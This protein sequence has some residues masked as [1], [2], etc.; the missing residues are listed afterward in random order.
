MASDE[1]RAL[2]QSTDFESKT[3]LRVGGGETPLKD[4]ASLLGTLDIDIG[5][6]WAK[7]GV[8]SHWPTGVV[9]Y[10]NL[11]P[12]HLQPTLYIFHPAFSYQQ[13]TATKLQYD[14]SSSSN[15]A[16]EYDAAV[17]HFGVD[18][19]L[20]GRLGKYLTAVPMPISATVTTVTEALSVDGKGSPFAVGIDGQGVG[21]PL[22]SVVFINA[23]S[24]EDSSPA[25][26]GMAVC[27]RAPGAKDRLLGVR[28]GTKL[29]YWRSLMGQGEKWSILKGTHHGRAAE[30]P[31]S[32]GQY[33]RQG[34]FI[35]LQSGT[36]TQSPSSA[37]SIMTNEHLMSLYEGVQ[38]AEIRL[39]HK[40]R[41]G[42]GAEL[43]QVDLFGA[44]PLP[45]WADRP[46]LSGKYLVLPPSTRNGGPEALSRAFPGAHTPLSPA[47]ALSTLPSARQ[48]Q[49]LVREVLLSL[50]GVEGEYIR[51]VSGAPDQA[52]RPTLPKLREIK[53]AMDMSTIDRA[54]ATQVATILPICEH[55]I[56]I[57]EFTRLHSRL[58]HGLVSHALAAAIKIVMREF[59]LLVAQLE[60]QAQLSN[61]SLQRIVFLLQPAKATLRLLCL[62]VRR[63]WDKAGGGLLDVLHSFSLE[64]GDAKAK[65]LCVHLLEKSSRPFLHMLSR[66]IFRGELEDAYKEF[67]IHEDTSISQE[68]LAEDFNAQYWE[69]RY[70]LKVAH[71]PKVFKNIASRALTAGKYLNVVKGCLETGLDVGLTSLQLPIE[72]DLVLD[73]EGSAIA[74]AEVV[75]EAYVYSSRAL[76]RLLEE[77]HG[78]LTHLKSLSRFFLLE[79]GDF[80]IQFMDTAEEELR[81]EA[82]DIALPRI[83]GLLQLAVQTSTLA[84]DPHKEDLSCTL[85]THNLIQHLHLIQSAGMVN[86]DSG[87]REREAYSSMSSQGFK[88]VEALTLDYRVNWPVSLLLSRRSITKYQLL[89]RLLYFSKHVELRVLGS[90]Q[91]HQYTK[92]L[93]VRASMGQAYCLRHRMLHFLQNFVYY[94]A[95]EVICP[96]VHEMNEG[97][98]DAQD[99]DE[100]LGLHERFLDTC[101]KECLLA[102][103]DLL[104]N[105]TKIMTT[106]LLFADQMR[107]FSDSS[108]FD[109]DTRTPR[110]RGGERKGST[111]SNKDAGVSAKRRERLGAQSEYV[112]NE[113]AHESFQRMLAKFADTFDAQVFSP[114]HS[115]NSS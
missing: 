49:L 11:L 17:I 67:M 103:Q 83:Q 35:L 42:L 115:V 93:D 50:T 80:F 26:Y 96:R 37:S 92:E 6:P 98:K 7:G 39:V 38:G 91:D 51:I 102:S 13:D 85:A 77:G 86:S 113:A 87:E 74:L 45:A 32:R 55:A 71:I 70:T 47:P 30:L 8:P 104:K 64:Q 46:Y 95:L 27:I 58:S 97:M 88:G 114:Q 12:T 81:R 110:E 112:R 18:C 29:G 44:Q 10:G 84:Q 94:M 62:L 24:R 78:L 66:W 75:E 63:L 99:M 31:K 59:D 40:D 21:D 90:W 111:A 23:E 25:R 22:D 60:Y 15:Q 41:A 101:L 48:Q 76:L 68:A 28:E 5:T 33:V 34:D 65:S 89:S 20:R 54:A 100:V 57:R 14:N 52:G 2:L 9:R 4:L 36:V 43:W 72:R 105:L 16:D 109:S 79:H 108:V 82:K 3:P 69:S 106:C 73:S 61:L 53:M 56:E 107:R 19:S 1:L